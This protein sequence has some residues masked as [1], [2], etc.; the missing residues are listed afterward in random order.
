[1][2]TSEQQVRLTLTRLVGGDVDGGVLRRVWTLIRHAVDG[3]Y[4]EGVLGVSQQVADVDM[5]AGETQLTRHK[6][7][8]VTAAGAAAPP[9][10]TAL[11]DDVV[12]HIITAAALLRRAPLEPQRRL[13][14]DGEDVLWS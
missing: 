5:G 8:V 12:D 1:M 6:L 11:T 13:I 9:T 3:L 2:E 14:D 10:A 7:Y 4:F